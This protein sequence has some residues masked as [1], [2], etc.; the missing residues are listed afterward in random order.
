VIGSSFSNRP[1]RFG[2]LFCREIEVEQAS[3]HVFGIKPRYMMSRVLKI[4]KSTTFILTKQIKNNYENYKIYDVPIFKEHHHMSAG[5][6][7]KTH[8]HAMLTTISVPRPTVNDISQS[9]Y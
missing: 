1:I 2:S 5:Q 9:L 6:K 8:S 7:D 4:T 3:K